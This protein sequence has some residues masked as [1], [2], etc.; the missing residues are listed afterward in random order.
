M[1][2]QQ[3]RK[4]KGGKP[5]MMLSLRNWKEKNMRGKLKKNKRLNN[6]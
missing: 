5:K 4:I 2:W 1:N 6:N 3:R